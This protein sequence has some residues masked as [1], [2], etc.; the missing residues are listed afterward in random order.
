MAMTCSISSALTTLL[1]L[2]PSGM[3]CARPGCGAELMR[4]GGGD[5][6]AVLLAYTEIDRELVTVTLRGSERA[7]LEYARKHSERD[8]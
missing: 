6:D 1:E 4:P 2:T 5:L 3:S 8:D 7:R